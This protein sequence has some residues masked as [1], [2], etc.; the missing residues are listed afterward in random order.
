MKAFF[1]SLKGKI[2][3]G[4]ALAGVV[5]A[6][7]IAV[8]LSKQGY[9]TIVVK[10]MNGAVT[11]VNDSKSTS[12]F[13]GQKLV[14][15]D[16]VSVATSADLTLLLDSDKY[17]YAEENSHFWI[18]AKGKK[19]KTRTV[20]RQDAGTNLYEIENKLTDSE[21]YNVNT[22]NATL[23]VRGTVFR[24]ECK[25]EGADTY[26]I[27]EVFE[28]EVYVEAIMQ[29]GTSTGDSRI[30]KAGDM[31]VIHSNN[32]ISEF[33]ISD[34]GDVINVIEYGKLPQATAYVLGNII[35]KG[36]TLSITKE[37]LFDVVGITDHRFV[38][39]GEVVEVSCTEDGYTI[40]KCEICDEEVKEEIVPAKKHKYGE[41]VIEKEPTK[42][43][44]GKRVATCEVCGYELI[45]EIEFGDDISD[46]TA[47]VDNVNYNSTK[48]G[49]EVNPGVTNPSDTTSTD[50]NAC[51]KGH[52][53][54]E[55]TTN[56]T[57]TKA[58]VVTKTC[59]VC[60]H[61]E[62]VRTIPALGH[63]YSTTVKVDVAA[64]C[65]KEGTKTVKCSRCSSTTTESIPKDSSNHNLGT[66]TYIDDTKHSSTC[67][68]CHE[69]IIKDHAG[70]LKP[71]PGLEY[72]MHV[73]VCDECGS[74]YDV[75]ASS[76]QHHATYIITSTTH[77]Q[78]C[79]ECGTELM[80]E[81]NH[82]SYD[83]GTHIGTCPICGEEN[84]TLVGP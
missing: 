32:T 58:G 3:A 14:D 44:K 66:A 1:G 47:P 25:T 36:R 77:K 70:S 50:S 60:G 53:F 49:E 78:V 68:W 2:I 73:K 82:V 13:L 74:E 83:P 21:Y 17:I 34:N 43:E 64:T 30:L 20:I 37:L 62:T 71:Y 27:V 46:T 59:T 31:A 51:A 41:W 28:G 35:D 63:N 29:D 76:D 22:S 16:E 48:P 69:E 33:L 55:T 5:V 9:R 40:Y 57:C 65:T 11:V 19:E 52:S 12:A 56:A 4:V 81:T 80:T 8:V 7:V 61:K 6:V 42:K 18:E 84:V 23:S 79:A 67:S 75:S 54:K 15:G 10:E 38:S 26:T 72:T 39:T 45:E 24:V